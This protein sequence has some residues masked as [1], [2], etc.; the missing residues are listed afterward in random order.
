VGI[1]TLFCV[2]LSIQAQSDMKEAFWVV[3][4][5]Q[6]QLSRLN[7]LSHERLTNNPP[8]QDKEFEPTQF[9]E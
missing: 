8:I 9:N 3:K 5:Y 1:F 7:C 6:I 2:N 4:V